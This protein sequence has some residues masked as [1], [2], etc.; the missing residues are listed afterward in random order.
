MS[1]ISESAR[2]YEELGIPFEGSPY[3]MWIYDLKTLAFLKVNQ[4]AVRV[5]GFSEE[6]FVRM[7][8]LDI[9]PKEDVERFLKSWKHPHDST[10]EKWWHIGRD[11]RAFPVSITSWKLSFE[12]HEAELVL[13]RKDVD[14]SL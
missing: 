2:H 5:Y 3:P 7:T 4:A 9:R 8:V 12:G 1:K 11:G 14:V 6:E 13:A 10:A